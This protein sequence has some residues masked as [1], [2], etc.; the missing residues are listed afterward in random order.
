VIQRVS[1]EELY[2][3]VWSEPI[4][5]IAQQFGLSPA[6]LKK[7]CVQAEIPFPKQEHWNARR[8]GRR[9]SQPPLPP[10]PPAMH[11]EVVFGGWH[12]ERLSDEEIL[13]PVPDVPVFTESI[14]EVRERMRMR[15]GR[16]NVRLTLSRPHP[17]IAKLLERE[18]RQR[19]RFRLLTVEP[20]FETSATRRRLRIL[21]ALFVG[22]DRAGAHSWVD[23]DAR[24]FRVTV[25]SETIHLR[26]NFSPGESTVAVRRQQNKTST[27]LR[28]AMGGDP[29]IESSLLAW[30]DSD[31][32]R[33]EAVL[34]D[35]AVEIL[36]SAEANFRRSCL[37]TQEWRIERRRQL[38]EERAKKQAAAERAEQER[39]AALARA[40]T[41]RLLAQAAAH[42]RACEIREFVSAVCKQANPCNPQDIERLGKWRKWALAH[43]DS[44]DPLIN[45]EYLAELDLDPVAAPIPD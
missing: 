10:R 5:V 36:T 39:L 25:N 37:R 43:A 28:L 21:S 44:I 42:Q 4:S 15:I 20:R 17:V 3:L 38:E 18:E 7:K 29:A 16:V 24:E 11:F 31:T 12:G 33:L 14:D 26:L 34:T 8:T 30:E 6:G 1:R 2:A 23:D 35:V 9:T 22:L 19:T 13:G 45:R 32:V 40:R 27:R 41:E